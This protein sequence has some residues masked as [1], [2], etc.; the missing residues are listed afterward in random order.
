MKSQRHLERCESLAYCHASQPRTGKLMGLVTE[1]VDEGGPLSQQAVFYDGSDSFSIK[2]N[3]DVR[4]SENDDREA[5]RRLLDSFSDL[6]SPY[7][8]QLGLPEG[9][10]RT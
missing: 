4:M 7:E 10:T 1:L 8:E 6:V 9:A 3:A 2:V 5:V